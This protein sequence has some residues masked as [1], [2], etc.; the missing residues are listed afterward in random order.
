MAD[1]KY[2]LNNPYFID[3]DGLDEYIELVNSGHKYYVEGTEGH[4]IIPRKAFNLINKPVDNSADNIVYL[5]YKQ[6]LKAHYLLYKCTTGPLKKANAIA[7]NIMK[8]KIKDIDDLTDEIIQ[9][10]YNETHK[11]INKEDLYDL[12][13]NKNLNYSEVAEKLNC[14][15]AQV[16]VY[17]RKYKL[18]T[19]KFNLHRCVDFKLNY[20]DL[21]EYYVEENHTKKETAQH[22][23][24]SEMTVSTFCKKNQISKRQILK[25]RVSYEELYDFHIIQ[26]KSR[27]ET[28]KHFG[29]SEDYIYRMLC[30]HNVRK[31]TKAVSDRFSITK[32]LMNT[33]NKNDL[34]KYYVEEDH[35][36]PETAKHFNCKDHQIKEVLKLWGIKKEIINYGR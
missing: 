33:I 24:V 18:N 31:Q 8:G 32:Y 25:N 19:L 3:N 36:R 35:T 17:L 15:P 26:N 29:I 23:N 14:S 13:I 20:K 28:C 9:N 10:I 4:H 22:F 27:K 21:Y 7:Y 12:Y 1:K 11:V 30:E 6:H 16:V 34:I 2:L 5:S